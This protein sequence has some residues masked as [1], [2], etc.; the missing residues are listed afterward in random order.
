M[1][2]CRGETPCVAFPRR[3]VIGALVL[4]REIS[5]E[6]KRT[7]HEDLNLGWSPDRD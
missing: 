4:Q 1:R 7:E 6:W 2:T 5:K 3:F